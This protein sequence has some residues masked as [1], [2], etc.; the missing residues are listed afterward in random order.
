VAVVRL[1]EKVVGCVVTAGLLALAVVCGAVQAWAVYVEPRL[2]GSP[3]VPDEVV[4]D[5]RALA[6]LDHVD[7]A[8]ALSAVADAYLDECQR[9][10]SPDNEGWFQ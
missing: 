5:R 7:F 8:R 1:S 6:Q 4:V 9:R 3:G 2:F 10:A